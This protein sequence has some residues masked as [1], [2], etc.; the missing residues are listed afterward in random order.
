M[1]ILTVALYVIL[2]DQG[3]K[4]CIRRAFDLYESVPLIPGFFSLTYVRNTG[5]AWGLFSSQNQLL[6]LLAAVMLVVLVIYHRK[7]MP[8]GMIHRIAL[9]LLCGGIVGNLF[10][11]LRLDYVTDFLDFHVGQ[12][13]WPAFNI[14]DSAICIGVG[15]YLLS[16]L[17]SSKTP[18]A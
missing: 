15:I 8:P 12:W 11:R 6:A 4:E 14:A 10:D 18:A 7:I 9:G 2:L 1:T 16:S 13:H 3:S 17:F 5:A